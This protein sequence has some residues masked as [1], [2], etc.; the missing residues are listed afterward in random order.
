MMMKACLIPYIKI[1]FFVY[2]EEMKKRQREQKRPQR[3]EPDMLEQLLKQ[4]P[5]VPVQGPIST[6][7]PPEVTTR[8]RG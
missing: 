1:N 3:S 7:L 5:S 6:P 2:M 4:M 8:P